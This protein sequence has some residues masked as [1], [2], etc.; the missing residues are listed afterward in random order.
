MTAAAAGGTGEARFVCEIRD[1]HVWQAQQL[2]D[3]SLGASSVQELT[4]GGSVAYYLRQAALESVIAERM[5]VRAVISIH[6]ALLGGVSVAE[7]AHVTG[8]TCEHVAD[9]WRLWADGQRHLNTQYPRLGLDQ[10]EY[11]QAAAV[12]GQT[13]DDEAGETPSRLPFTQCACP[14]MDAQIGSPRP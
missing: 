11:E 5:R 4:G 2:L 3:A 1:L 12:I 8:S 9:C 13:A 6:R 7:I 10:R 14:A